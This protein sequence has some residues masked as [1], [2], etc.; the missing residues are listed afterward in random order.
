M[1]ADA[2]VFDID[3]TLWDAS[4][5]SAEGWNEGLAQLGIDKKVSAEQIAAVAGRPYELCVDT[6]LPGMREA[7]PGL[8]GILGD[9]EHASVERNGGKFFD[10]ALDAV[11][12]LAA[13]H[14]VLLASNCQ[15][16]YLQ[17]FLSFSGLE[18]FLSGVDCYGR[19]GLPKPEM[20]VRMRHTH[21]WA[22]PIYVGDTAGDESAAQA[23]AMTYMHCSWGFGCP[24]GTPTIV[25][26]FA[27]LV[28]ILDS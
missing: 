3:G 25:S 28:S 18:P 4:A 11:A 16:W 2:I 7:N 22:S 26:S 19:S 21:S 15:E 10:G 6:L 17:L 13:D 27:E 14:E 5:A 23:A 24:G 12:R 8:L 1:I 9:C 20:L